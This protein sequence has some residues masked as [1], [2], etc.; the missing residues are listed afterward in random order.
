M[1]YAEVL[2]GGAMN[3]EEHK[4]LRHSQFTQNGSDQ[5]KQL[6]IINSFIIMNNNI[7]LADL[8]LYTHFL[9]VL[10]VVLPVP[11]IIIGGIRGWNWVRNLWFRL[12]HLLLIGFVVLES[13][14]RIPCPLTEWEYQLRYST[15]DVEEYGSFISNWVSRILYYEADPMLF[16]V[17]YVLFGLLI[18]SLLY[19]VP[20]KRREDSERGHSD[21]KSEARR[22]L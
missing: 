3:I 18:A 1:G 21:W 8:L 19:F 16:N 7:F 6:K 11:L 2:Y 15:H 17:I 20:V 13:V 4:P 10:C 22:P 14:F 12:I 5:L 9:Y